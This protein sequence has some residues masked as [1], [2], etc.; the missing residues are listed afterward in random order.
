[1][2]SQETKKRREKGKFLKKFLEKKI[3]FPDFYYDE[4]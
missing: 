4:Y 2:Q 3:M 1:M